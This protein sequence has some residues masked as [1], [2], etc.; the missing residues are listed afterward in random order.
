MPQ[1]RSSCREPAAH[2]A[3]PVV[4]L[5]LGRFLPP[6]ERVV[7]SG[8]GVHRVAGVD[9]EDVDVAEGDGEGRGLSGGRLRRRVALSVVLHEHAAGQD[10]LDQIDEVV[11]QA[12]GAGPGSS[13]MHLH[14]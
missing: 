12:E 5:R 4:V 3:E 2:A 9:V 8:D 10:S 7:A 13:H 6:V 1:T 11:G 14:A